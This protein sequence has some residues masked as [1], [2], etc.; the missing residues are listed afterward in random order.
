VIFHGGEDFGRGMIMN[1]QTG[2]LQ[3]E[4]PADMTDSWDR[5]QFMNPYTTYFCF[6]ALTSLVAGLLSVLALNISITFKSTLIVYPVT[7]LIWIIFVVKRDSIVYAIQ[8]FTEHDPG[9][10]LLAIVH[11][12]VVTIFFAIVAF[13]LSGKK[14]SDVLV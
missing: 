9:E 12:L 14:N 2:L 1:E 5:I 11:F 4:N 3:L 10:F 13:F 6:M 7:F 8:P